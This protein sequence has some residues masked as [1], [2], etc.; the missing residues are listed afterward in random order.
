MEGSTTM[1]AFLLFCVLLVA[2]TTPDTKTYKYKVPFWFDK[3]LDDTD[4]RS[5]GNRS[6]LAL[7]IDH[8]TGVHYIKSPF[9]SLTPRLN[10]D[11]EIVTEYMQK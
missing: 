11:G 7:Y 3:K 2:L 6:N 10:S 4:D 1:I 8:G 5:N 9:G